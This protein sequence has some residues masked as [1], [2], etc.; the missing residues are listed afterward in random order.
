MHPPLAG[1]AS[2]IFRRNGENLR[3]SWLFTFAIIFLCEV[4]AGQIPKTGNASFGYSYSQGQV[5]SDAASASIN[6]NGW[7]GS[8]EGKF[9]PCLGVIAALDSH[10]GDRRL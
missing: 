10:S 2:K 8:V 3:N 7:E 6:T 1:S 5:L 4:A 9:L